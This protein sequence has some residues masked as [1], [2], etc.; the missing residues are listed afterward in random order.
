M[1]SSPQLRALRVCRGLLAV[2][3]FTT[4]AAAQQPPAAPFVGRTLDSV[5]LVVEGQPNDDRSLAEA[6]QTKIGRPLSMTDVRETITHLYSF[7]RFED[8]Q[9]KAEAA[10]DGGVGLRFELEPIHIVTR[11][12][13]KG[14]LGL[15]EG[16][17]RSRM[18]DRV[19]AM[20]PLSRAGDVAA[21]L[22]DLYHERGYLSA[23]VKPAPPI[24]E[25]EPHRATAIFDVSAGPQTK[26]AK[27]TVL[28]H[29]LDSID[30]VRARLQIEPGQPYEPGELQKRLAAYVAS[31]RH[32]RRY[33]AGAH[34][35]K[36]T[37]SE[38]RKTVDVTINVEAGPLV[39]IQF[40]G[41][42]L[43]DGKIENLVPIEREGS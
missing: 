17:L 31:M 13:F 15:S 32:Q 39:R 11:V 34:E 28:G 16:T 14:D 12:E 41:D 23:T 35:E 33:E 36:P 43:P 25:H 18:T 10:V 19:G 26:I 42:P 24:L 40:E 29:P 38:D 9:V 8:V 27:S 5:V 22:V 7:G 4:T 6:I 37:F 30:S 1:R 21:A 3:L 2:S 20:P